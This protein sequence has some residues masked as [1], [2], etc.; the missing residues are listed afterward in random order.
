MYRKLFVVTAGTIAAG[1][2]QEIVRQ[3]NARPQSDLKVM[4]RCIDTAR[5]TNRY[6]MRDGEWFQ[7][8]VDPVYMKALYNNR[9]NHPRLNRLLYPGLL[10]KPTGVGGGSIR[11]NGSGAVLVN[12]DNLKKWLSA[13]MTG[14]T[15]LGDNQ[16]NFSVAL[17]VSSVGATGSGSLDYLA[18]V[19]AEAAQEANVP[20]PIRMDIFILQPGME[21]VS[22]L[23][24]VNT[25]AL[26][27]ELAASR[28]AQNDM[29]DKQYQGRIIMVGWGSTR[30]LS[31]I[32]HLE[33]TAATLVRL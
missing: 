18:D 24:L 7:M 15:R 4:V 10:P 8:T 6:S 14:L 16:T 13:N 3:M 23:G 12:R 33:E 28:L 19:I 27:A 5:L 32:E 20:I 22:Q 29:Y 2:G 9:A 26:Y 21:G 31:S 11:Y 17:I 25:L 30:S 1:V